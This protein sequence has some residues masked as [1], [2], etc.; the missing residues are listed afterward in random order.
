MGASKRRRQAPELQSRQTAE[1]QQPTCLWL[2]PLASAHHTTTQQQ[3]Q[4]Q[5]QRLRARQ[6]PTY[7]LSAHAPRPP[8]G[9]SACRWQKRTA[10]RFWTGT[11]L[12]FGG[13]SGGG[14]KITLARHNACHWQKR[15]APLS[16]TEHGCG[17]DGG[18]L[19]HNEMTFCVHASHNSSPTVVILCAVPRI[20]RSTFEVHSRR[21]TWSR[22]WR[23]VLLKQQLDRLL[24]RLLAAAD[25]QAASRGCD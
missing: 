2:R 12:H 23:A 19:K 18:W 6:Q 11:R 14:S 16:W 22:T 21:A 1:M 9:S 8:P 10:P 25:K 20:T 5:Q 15:T 4:Q 17:R 7:P 13:E 24:S 3:Q